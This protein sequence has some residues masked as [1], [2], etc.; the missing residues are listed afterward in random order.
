MGNFAYIPQLDE[1][2]SQKATDYAL[3]GKLGVSG[4]DTQLSQSKHRDKKTDA[5]N[6]N[7]TELSQP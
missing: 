7:I 4:L 3:M 5:D 2:S 1:A 6:A